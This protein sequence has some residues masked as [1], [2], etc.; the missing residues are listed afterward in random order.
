MMF[1]VQNSCLIV[2][3]VCVCVCLERVLQH[4]KTDNQFFDGQRRALLIISIA[5]RI[6]SA[7]KQQLQVKSSQF[8]SSS[9]QQQ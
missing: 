5:N 7:E 2:M 8:N 9:Q 6:E 1:L 3:C 4:N